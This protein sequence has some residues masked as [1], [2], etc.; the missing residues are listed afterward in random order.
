MQKSIGAAS[1][2]VF[3][4]LVYAFGCAPDAQRADWVMVALTVA[5]IY[6]GGTQAYIYWRQA[7]LMQETL[8]AT[9]DSSDAAKRSADAVMALEQPRIVL[10]VVSALLD[11]S[12]NWDTDQRVIRITYK[13]TNYG[14]TPAWVRRCEIGVVNMHDPRAATAV[15]ATAHTFAYGP[16][17]GSLIAPGAS[18]EAT[19][20]PQ[21]VTVTE[22]NNKTYSMDALMHGTIDYTDVFG[23]KRSTTFAWMLHWATLLPGD[24]TAKV[25]RGPAE[26]WRRTRSSS[27]PSA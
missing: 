8:K 4:I 9:Q 3:L 12:E 16:V 19:L 23:E 2:A 15:G 22:Q 18:E 6:V 7:S 14:R 1:A 11:A 5:L 20:P 21:A 25:S 26:Y 10:S 13:L 24:N 17:D 27:A